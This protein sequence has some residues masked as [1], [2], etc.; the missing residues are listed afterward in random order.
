MPLPTERFGAQSQNYSY[1][2]RFSSFPMKTIDI[3]VQYYLKKKQISFTIYHL[4]TLHIFLV[5]AKIID[6]YSKPFCSSCKMPTGQS[7]NLN[8]KSNW[9]IE[10]TTYVLVILRFGKNCIWLNI[11]FRWLI[12]LK[13]WS[14]TD[15]TF[16]H[17]T[18]Q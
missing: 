15:T 7:K 8:I 18:L 4:M 10:F 3:S 16:S 2:L 9:I 13:I 14:G 11:G 12:I 1:F 17:L 5:L 6:C